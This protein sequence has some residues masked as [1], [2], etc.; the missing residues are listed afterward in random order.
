METIIVQ[1]SSSEEMILLK[2]FLENKNI[3]NHILNDEDKEDFI[4][5][6]LMKETDYN[7]IIDAKTFIHQLQAK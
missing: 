3:K 7:D 2:E 6:L 1:P 5:G 4:L